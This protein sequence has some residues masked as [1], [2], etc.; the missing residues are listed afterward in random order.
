MEPMEIRAQ[1]PNLI[2]AGLLAVTLVILRIMPPPQLDPDFNPVA[3]LPAMA[4]GL[5]G[6]PLR[7]C[8]IETCLRSFESAPN[9]PTDCPYCGGPSD[10]WSPAE[11]RQLPPDT[12]LSRRIYHHPDGRR[13]VAAVVTSGRQRTSVHRPQMC[14][15]GQGFV[16]ER[17]TTEILSRADGQPLEIRRLLLRRPSQPEQPYYEFVYWFSGW[18]GETTSY[19]RLAAWNMAD[20]LWHNRVR[21][22]AYVSMLT[23]R[24]DGDPRPLDPAFQAFVVSLH[25]SL[26]IPD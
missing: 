21:P 15:P 11:R 16:I 5:E 12:G 22:W 2:V 24:P 18:R 26:T 17:E 23:A 4:G 13:F 19:L 14:L 25:Q 1:T 20:S 8:T 9:E 10:D 3:P 7:Y 6:E